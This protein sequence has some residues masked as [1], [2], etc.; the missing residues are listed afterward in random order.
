LAQWRRTWV[1]KL[2][3]KRLIYLGN[4]QNQEKEGKLIQHLTEAHEQQFSETVKETE[5]FFTGM[6]H[7]NE[8]V[9]EEVND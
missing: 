7:L 1:C 2:S 3:R 6:G 5:L 8:V 4:V 9:S